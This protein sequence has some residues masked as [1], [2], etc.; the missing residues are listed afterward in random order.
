M[1]YIQSL[2]SSD[3]FSATETATDQKRDDRKK[4]K[5]Q[6]KSKSSPAE[7]TK[8]KDL[9]GA[10]G[11]LTGLHGKLYGDMAFAKREY[12]WGK[13]DAK[14]LD[15]I[16]TLF[17]GILIP[18][19]GMGTITDIFERIAERRGWVEPHENSFDRAESWE[20][21]DEAA[22]SEEKKVWNEVMKAL[23][24]PFAVVVAAMDEGIEHASLVLEI[25]PK[26]K[27]KKEADVE[28]NGT[29]PRPGDLEF[30]S[31][32]N[33]KVVDFHSKR[34]ETLKAWA[35]EKGL[36]KDQFDNA[37]SAPGHSDNFTPDEAHH[38]R[39]QQQLYLMLYMEHL[40][41]FCSFIY[42]ICLLLVPS[43]EQ[44]VLRW[45]RDYYSLY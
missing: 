9:K 22:K 45:T 21:L 8:A 40:V 10:I 5:N 43:L 17:R 1:A 41:R 42:I 2:E 23:H 37:K 16:F 30:A 20:H 29:D 4:R 25:L 35:R 19:V 11:A 32:L 26:P 28:E 24:E 3:M 38:R 39:D 18:L 15:E 34:G 44:T 13:L 6:D 36:S 12:A 27:K 31:F 7:T 33:Q 14:D